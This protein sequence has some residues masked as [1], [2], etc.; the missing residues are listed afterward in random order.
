[1]QPEILHLA[2]MVITAR[3]SNSFRAF[4]LGHLKEPFVFLPE[5]LHIAKLQTVSSLKS[6]LKC[7]LR[8]SLSCECIFRSLNVFHCTACQSST[9]C[10]KNLTFHFSALVYVGLLAIY[11]PDKKSK[12]QGL[13]FACLFMSG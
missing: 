5:N 12:F 7:L 6:I 4:L 2:C 9:H 8:N 13:F 11:W 1:M 3:P 10:A